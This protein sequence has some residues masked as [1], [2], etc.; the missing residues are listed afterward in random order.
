MSLHAWQAWLFAAAV[1]AGLGLVYRHDGWRRVVLLYLYL[2]V[3]VVTQLTVHWV[4]RD[5]GFPFSSF[6]TF[7]QFA[8][9]ATAS[10]AAAA[11]QGGWRLLA[12]STVGGHS[13]ELPV[14]SLRF[15]NFYLRRVLPV[16]LTI[17]GSVALN[18][19]SLNIIDPG[20]NAVL[21]Q[22]TPAVT[23]VLAFSLCGTRY[24]PAGWFAVALAVIGGCCALLGGMQAAG[25]VS[26]TARGES[27]RHWVGVGFSLASML[28]RSL[29]T[30]VL[31]RSLR[32]GV[33][34]GKR[35]DGAA[36]AAASL[37]LPALHPWQ[38]LVMQTPGTA[39]VL[40]LVASVDPDGLR[41]PLRVLANTDGERAW[42][43]YVGVLANVVAA[44]CLSCVGMLVLQRLGATAMQI[45]G[46]TNTFVVMAFS[47]AYGGETLAAGEIIGAAL[48]LLSAYLFSAF[49]H[50][51]APEGT[52]ARPAGS[53]WAVLRGAASGRRR[54]RRQVL[55]ELV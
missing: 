12:A 22:L 40:L 26:L 38:M 55:P 45:V 2:L 37:E 9:L 28:L 52:A 31:E 16:V 27:S 30:V 54:G 20:F 11:L 21:G 39:L 42:L 7:L 18:N 51:H 3:L 36:A 50:A 23:A 41:G 44:G 33:G 32:G 46:K 47:A 35:G 48:V 34:E 15:A 53:P 5:L 29:K 1:A 49:G 14:L 25:A 17:A 43:M 13:V 10:S 6:L 24:S 19:A 8:V 4:L